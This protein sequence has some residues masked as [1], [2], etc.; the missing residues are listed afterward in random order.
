[1]ALLDIICIHFPQP[2]R[3]LSFKGVALRLYIYHIYSIKQ[4]PLINTTQ[5]SFFAIVKAHVAAEVKLEMYRRLP[6]LLLH[7][8]TISVTHSLTCT[9][10]KNNSRRMR[11]SLKMTQKLREQLCDQLASHALCTFT[12]KLTRC[13]QEYLKIQPKIK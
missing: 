7:L 4:Y 8:K 6:S 5:L 3:T 1:M 2:V 12:Y 11:L 10:M 13:T 9:R